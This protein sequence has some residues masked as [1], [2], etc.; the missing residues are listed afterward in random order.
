MVFVKIGDD[1][2]ATQLPADEVGQGV[3]EFQGSPFFHHLLAF[4]VG[5]RGQVGVGERVFDF[6]APRFSASVWSKR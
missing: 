2:A 4:F 1:E 6:D 5:E 3:A